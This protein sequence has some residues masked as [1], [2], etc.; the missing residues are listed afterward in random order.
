MTSWQT[1]TLA[2][3]GPVVS[4][5]LLWGILGNRQD[6]HRLTALEVRVE[7]LAEQTTTMR[8]IVLGLLRGAGGQ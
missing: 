2:V 3:G 8:D 5:L 1:W 6:A 7:H 4:G